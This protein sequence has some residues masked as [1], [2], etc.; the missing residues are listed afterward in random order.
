MGH[1]LPTSHR[2]RDRFP[3]ISWTACFYAAWLSL[4]VPAVALADSAHFDIAAQPL[5]QALKAFAA[6]SHMQ[7]LYEYSAVAKVKVKGNAVSG[8]LERHEAL[9]QLL[10]NSGLEVIYSSDSVATI[11]PVGPGAS[12][13]A[14][15][16]PL[17][18]TKPPRSSDD[19][20]SLQLV[21]PPPGETSN[22]LA[23]RKTGGGLA[24]ENTDELQ[25]VSP[26]PNIPEILVK[27]SRIMNVDVTRTEDDVLPYTIF[28]A[29]Q[30]Q[31]SGATNVEDFLKQ[32]LTM[33]TTSQMNSQVNAQQGTSALGTTS[34]INLRGLGSNET[35]ILIDGR[36]TAGVSFAGNSVQPDIN[37]IPLSA[38][39]KIEVLPSSASAI[40]GGAAVG[41]VVNIILKRNFSGGDFSYTYD[42]PE[43]SSASQRT[44]SGSYGTTFNEGRTQLFVGGQYS[45]QSPVLLG[46]R[47]NLEQRGVNTILGNSPAFF[48]NPNNP[49]QGAATN[50]A[51]ADNN[52]T[53][54]PNGPIFVPIPLTLKNGTPLNSLIT[55]IPA[56]AA[57]GSNLAP[58]LLADAGKYN[59]GFPPGVG[60]NGLQNSF[61]SAALTK[62]LF[63]TLRQTIFD[64][65]QLFTEFS[66]SSNAGRTVNNPFSQP[67]FVPASA[68][69]NPFQQDVLVTFPSDI[70]AAQTSDSVTQSATLGV[71]VPLAHGWSS[72]ADYTWSRNSFEYAYDTSDA[73]FLT[74]LTDGTLNPFVDTVAHPLNLVSYLA[75]VTYSGKS[76]LNDV[77][78]RASGPVGSL[79]AGQPTLTVGVEHRKAASSNGN[80]EVDNPLTPS[81]N[82]QQVYFGQSQ[83][84]DSVY[85]EA[86]VPLITALN[87]V[88]A[89]HSLDLEVAGRSERYTVHAESDY[90]YILPVASPF[91]PSPPQG[92]HSTIQYTSTNPTIGLKYQ[93]TAD[94][95]ARASYSTGFLPPTP[96]QLLANPLPVC[97]SGIPC[98]LITDPKNGET[99]PVNQTA[100]GN[101]NLQP[102]T[103]RDLDLG[104]IWAPQEEMLRGLRL[105]LEYYRITQPNYIE[106]PT[107]QA[108]VNIPGRSTRDPTTGL[109]TSVNLEPLNANDYKTS[110][111]DVKADYRRPTDFGTF[112]LHTA[113]TFIKYDLRQL[114]IDGPYYEYAGFTN[115]GGEAKIKANATLSW[116]YRRWTAAWTSTYYSGYYQELSPGSPS[117][118]QQ[119]TALGN[120]AAAQ[121][122]Y[123]I[124]SQ[125]YHDLYVSYAF[126]HSGRA[127]GVSDSHDGGLANTLLSNVTVSFGIKNVF[128]TLPPFDAFSSYY[129]SSYGDPRLRDFR[130][131]VKKGFH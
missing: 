48:Y 124:P 104:M 58:G 88:P 24:V 119:L 116:E 26:N 85:A 101:P 3:Q 55:S 117:G 122:G 97:P 92:E 23:V 127:S 81:Q 110:G 6:Q 34:T 4:I 125:I 80:Y 27:G 44:L 100:G 106:T 63:T 15:S 29:E 71:V 22:G 42:K 83:S 94:F 47:L 74:A 28:S 79:P 35:L 120:F 8:D 103:S 78:L 59:V 20:S 39:E 36:R 70:A 53:F 105:D 65:V 61:G 111:W 130:L 52:I 40:Y 18:D 128:N 123:T 76:T 115:D 7:L 87:H 112:G 77:T 98:A 90:D 38:I 51:S 30:I 89:I 1:T 49:F 126:A 14:A 99:Y 131:T 62:S 37:G 5:L 73:A 60:L 91:Y 10:K 95:T 114:A 13:G 69:D 41:G 109:I 56:G 50:I 86:L 11:R 45:D 108:A 33:N 25:G 19:R 68:P 46:D 64:D 82:V 43:S 129:Y 102:Q 12:S 21:Q 107:A 118:L 72:E 17:N 9:A 96:A 32:Q 2:A 57:V 16:P 66:T 54:G 121:G 84:T 31:L 93:P 113:A 67:G 75:P